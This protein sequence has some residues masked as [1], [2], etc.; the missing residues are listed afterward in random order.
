MLES[1][2]DARDNET[3]YEYDGFDRLETR[4]YPDTTTEEYTYDAN[5][6]VL[7]LTTR[8]SDVITNTYDVLTRLETRD[9]GSLPLQTMTYDLAGRLEK[10][11]TPST[12]DPTS[13]DYEWLYDTAG[14][15]LTQKMP[16]AREVTYELDEN[17]NKTKLI[18]PDA[19]YVEYF[20]DEMNR[21]T[22]IKLNGAGTSAVEF[23]Y[24]DLSRRI[25]A[26][27]EN[28]CECA[29]G[30]ELNDDLNALEHT[31]DASS[32]AWAFS[33]NR[34]HQVKA[35]SCDN[36]AYVWTPGASSTKVYSTANSLNQ[37][38]AVAGTGFSYDDNGNKT[39]QLI[40]TL[41][42]DS[43]KHTGGNAKAKRKG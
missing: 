37:Y 14:R 41:L 29:Y 20:Y 11:N 12:S 4:T 39:L 24:D 9:P 7:T 28:G 42:H 5:N 13:G 15:L 6:Q 26:T 22:D 2:Q 23:V 36:S 32:V 8:A 10:L 17:G 34:V 25:T 1:I 35:M 38:P 43:V 3:L 21:L 31:F 40:P 27:Y 18:W 16:D 19:Y 33:Y 30:Y